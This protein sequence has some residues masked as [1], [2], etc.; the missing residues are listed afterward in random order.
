MDSTEVLH[1]TSDFARPSHLWNW[2]TLHANGTEHGWH[3]HADSLVSG[4]YFIRTPPGSGPL[5]FADPRQLHADSV[6]EN[7]PSSSPFKCNTFELQPR[8]GDLVLFPS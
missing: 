2:A 6:D 1:M 5:A 3:A 8:A 4:I 7:R